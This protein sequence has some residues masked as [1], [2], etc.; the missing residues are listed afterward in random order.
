MPRMSGPRR[1]RALLWIWLGLFALLIVG[2]TFLRLG[3]HKF[4]APEPVRASV[5]RVHGQVSDF[6]AAKTADGRVLLFD[7]GA[8]PEGRGLDALLATLKATREDVSDIFLTHGHGDHI[9]A[10]PLCPRARVHG[11]IG[12][13]DMMSK[14]GPIVPG[15]AR[16]MGLVLPTPPVMLTDAFLDRAAVP[17][18]GDGAV[19]EVPFAGHTPGSVLYLYDG[20]LFA[21]DSM[22]FDKDKL[23][24]AFAPFSVD[25]K[26]NKENIAALPS[27]IKLDDVK[28]V[29]TAHGG[30]SPEA[31][32]RRM[33]DEIVKKA[34]S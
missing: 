31:G 14:R 18:G 2:I 30:C 33:L 22:N 9:A 29:C 4:A 26:K 1:R 20:V 21:G 19:L 34:K 28:V 15:F 25:T 8:D 23:T 10:T 7:T 6:F 13:S 12:D 11:G 5:M 16:F 32:T 24:P 27:L 3:R 17:V